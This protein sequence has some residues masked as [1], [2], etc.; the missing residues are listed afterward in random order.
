MEV[1]FGT[2]GMGVWDRREQK[3]KYKKNV[4]D[5]DEIVEQLR[6]C[7]DSIEEL[8]YQMQEIRNRIDRSRGRAADSGDEPGLAFRCIFLYNPM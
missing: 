4:N 7:A 2:L 6:V 3:L 1:P 8:D 5:T